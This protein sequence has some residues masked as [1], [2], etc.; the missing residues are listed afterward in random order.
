M[1]GQHPSIRG[2][3]GAIRQVGK[4]ACCIALLG[5]L[6]AHNAIAQNAARRDLVVRGL[7]FSGNRAIDDYTLSISIATSNSSW[8]ARLPIRIFGERPV[9]S[10]ADS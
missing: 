1:F 2:G 9:F 5:L 8:W 7:H 6:G 3:G 4:L 10:P